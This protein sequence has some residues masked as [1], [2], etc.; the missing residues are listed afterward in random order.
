M[1]RKGRAIITQEIQHR[2]ECGRVRFL[3]LDTVILATRLEGAP[4]FNRFA[5]AHCHDVV[6]GGSTDRM[7]RGHSPPV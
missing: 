6:L 1:L 5:C 2:C 3:P 7:S 4:G